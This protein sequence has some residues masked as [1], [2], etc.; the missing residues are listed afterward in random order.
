[1]RIQS[2]ETFFL[3]VVFIAFTILNGILSVKIINKETITIKR[4]AFVLLSLCTVFLICFLYK[5]YPELEL[6][7]TKIGIILYGVKLVVIG[8]LF[9][10]KNYK[11]DNSVLS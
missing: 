5:M 8:L 9:I 7:I 11:H 10:Y 4:G 6:V 1:M 3:S 2:E